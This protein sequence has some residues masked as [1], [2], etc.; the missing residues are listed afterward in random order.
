LEYWIRW[1]WELAI[2][3]KVFAYAHHNDGDAE[4]RKTSAMRVEA[5]FLDR[6]NASPKKSGKT[7]PADH[8][9]KDGLQHHDS[10]C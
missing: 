8:V 10:D 7:N 1:V 2:Q 5:L 3:E 4:L 9:N 6:T